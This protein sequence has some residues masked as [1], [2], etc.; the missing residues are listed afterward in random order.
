MKEPGMTTTDSSQTSD[1]SLVRD[2]IHAVSYLRGWRGPVAITAVV[3]VTGIAFGWSWLVA[4]GVAPLLLS[5]LPCAVMCALGLCM[6]R[7]TGGQCSTDTVSQKPDERS[8]E[9]SRMPGGC[10]SSRDD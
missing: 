7:L 6:N 1:A 10:D 5:V 3:A 4:A 2:V 9:P 8:G